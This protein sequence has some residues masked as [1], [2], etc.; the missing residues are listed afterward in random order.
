MFFFWR[1]KERRA[2]PRYE[3]DNDFRVHFHTIDRVRRI[4]YG[5][6]RDVSVL[7]MRFVTYARVKKGDK[8]DTVVD[9]TPHFPGKKSIPL[10]M[11]VVR[12]YRRKG[13]KRYRVGVRYIQSRKYEP[14]FYIVREFVSWIQ[15]KNPSQA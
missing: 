13:Q 10:E 5:H 3:A 7:G 12:V 4:G 1:K 11:E 2:A 6:G 15:S 9:F 14:E 8:L